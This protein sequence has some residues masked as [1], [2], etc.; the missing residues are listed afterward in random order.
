MDQKQLRALEARCT[1]EEPPPCQAGCPIGVDV[2]G[3]HTEMG[4]KKYAQAR[5]ILEKHIPLSP[6]VARLCEGPCQIFCH[7]KDL[8]GSINTPQLEKFCI[9]NSQSKARILPLP[10]KPHKVAI[11]GSGPDALTASFDLV[12]KGYKTF[13][14]HL[15]EGPGSWLIGHKLLTSEILDNEIAGLKKLG[16]QFIAVKKLNK[17]NIPVDDYKALLLSDDTQEL[18]DGLDVPDQETGQ[19]DTSYFASPFTDSEHPFIDAIAGGRLAALSIDRFLQGASLTASR[20]QLRRGKTELYVNTSEIKPEPLIVAQTQGSYTEEEATAEANRCIRCECLECVK[21][22][23]FLQ[24]YKAFPK[25]YARRIYN[26]SAIVKGNHQANKMINSCSLCR[27]C[28]VVCP[29]DFSMADLCL[30]AR[31]LMIKENRMPPSA[32]HFA[33]EEMHSATAEGQFMSHAKGQEKSQALFFPGCQLAGIR[34]EQSAKLYEL[35]TEV[36]PQT[37]LWLDCCGA[38]LYWGGRVEEFAQFTAEFVRKWRSMGE[39]EIITACS[40]CQYIFENHLVDETGEKVSPKVKAAWQSIVQLD[41]EPTGKG[42]LLAVSDPCTARHNSELQEAIRALVIKT[43][44]RLSPLAASKELTECCGFG[45]LM[46]SCN[47]ELATKV[48]TARAAQTED[49]I[50]TYCAM[51]RD[52]IAKTGKDVTHILD[53]LF[54][55]TAIASDAP[56]VTLSGRRHNRR[57]LK[58]HFQETLTGEITPP[59]DWEA[60]PLHIAPDVAETLKARRILLDDIQKTLH[61][62]CKH[63]RF[64]QHGN[65]TT[66]ICYHTIGTVTYWV[67]YREDDGFQIEAA[68][69]HRM[70]IEGGP[71]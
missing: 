27:Q 40:S 65:G 16:V 51:C 48:V 1:Q 20:V 50:L 58:T 49:T 32:Q 29:N 19:I 37:G 67:Q 4:K 22:C 35:L 13:L 43:G 39:P 25:A 17:E 36:Q 59:Q 61:Y 46:E 28:E 21:K 18:R 42:T 64:F 14:Y 44:Y 45:G 23:T 15:E 54:V 10:P 38:P 6:I 57:L 47:Q 69:S 26:N 12:K 68:W 34:P 24:E 60:I 3:F 55:D 63:N 52:Q 31:S 2:R 41:I 5:K 33:L 8:G 71:K 56:P 7:R 53:L 30:E 66:K 70:T 9:E 11:V 62:A